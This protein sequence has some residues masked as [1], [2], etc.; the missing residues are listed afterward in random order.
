MNQARKTSNTAHKINTK[1]IKK[2]AILLTKSTQKK[3]KNKQK[4]KEEEQEEKRYYIEIAL[5]GEVLQYI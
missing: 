1:K 4:K 5:R 2:Q 3:S